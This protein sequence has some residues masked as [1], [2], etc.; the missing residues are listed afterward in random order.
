M[1][2]HLMSAIKKAPVSTSSTDRS[3]HYRRCA[4]ARPMS[5]S[6]TFKD[7][8]GSAASFAADVV[9]TVRG[10]DRCDV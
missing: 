3:R 6:E 9:G 7:R 4:P 8:N 2:E 5:L 10:R 1:R